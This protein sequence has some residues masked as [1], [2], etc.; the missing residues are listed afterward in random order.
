MLSWQLFR[1]C[2][3]CDVEATP[4]L[5]PDHSR[6]RE[7]Q[8]RQLEPAEERDP[9]LVAKVLAGLGELGPLPVTFDA[10][11][12]RVGGDA[13]ELC[14]AVMTACRH[15][16]ATLHLE[17]PTVGTAD[18]ERP[19][20]NAV[21]RWQAA[22]KPVCGTRYNRTIGLSGEPERRLMTVIDGTRTREEICEAF[23]DVNGNRLAPPGLEAALANLAGIGML[24]P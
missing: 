8:I 24:D 22:R 4:S 10:L 13:D 12:E 16:Q 14:T 6:V 20:V 9:P 11:H 23:G 1:S 18:A 7:M 5:A 3:L 21:A 19:A 2:V 17:P 15:R